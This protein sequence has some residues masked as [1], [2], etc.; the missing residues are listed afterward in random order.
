MLLS[1]F[2][3]NNVRLWKSTIFVYFYYFVMG[4]IYWSILFI[5][6]LRT[7]IS[8]SYPKLPVNLL[9]FR[10]LRN[11]RCSNFLLSLIWIYFFAIDILLSNFLLTCN[12]LKLFGF[13]MFLFYLIYNVNCSVTLLSFLNCLK[14]WLFAL[15]KFFRLYISDVQHFKFLL[16]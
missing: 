6:N 10:T 8:V 7:I 2:C 12:I 11:N 15:I 5:N 3:L 16:S 13:F 9:L 14:L 1:N 4:L